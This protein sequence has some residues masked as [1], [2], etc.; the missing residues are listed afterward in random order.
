[1][2]KKKWYTTWY[3][4]VI[5][6]TENWMDAIKMAARYKKIGFTGIKV[7]DKEPI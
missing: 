6:E 5:F 3:D 4:S 7:T 1:M 2:S